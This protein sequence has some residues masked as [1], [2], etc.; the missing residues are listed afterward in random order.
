M[1]KTSL[2][3]SQA[4]DHIPYEI[5]P[6]H[7]IL[8]H[9][10]HTI[11]YHIL[12]Y[13]AMSYRTVPCHTSKYD[14]V[15][16]RKAR[17]VTA[18]SKNASYTRW[19]LNIHKQRV[20]VDRPV[21][22]GMITR[23]GGHQTLPFIRYVSSRSTRDRSMTRSLKLRVSTKFSVGVFLFFMKIVLRNI[24]IGPRTPSYSPPPLPVHLERRSRRS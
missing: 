19:L 18:A 15:W 10:N 14:N 1:R 17:S 12:K 22:P 23:G 3:P 20:Y 9:T 16:L 13:L 5:I 21:D 7:T 8:Y 6:S 11:R 2:F 4:S 24:Y